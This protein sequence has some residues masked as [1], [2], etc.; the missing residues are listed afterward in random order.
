MA[1]P[2]ICPLCKTSFKRYK[3]FIKH[4]NRYSEEDRKKIFFLDNK[5]YVQGKLYRFIDDEDI[6]D[7]E[8]EEDQE[9]EELEK[10]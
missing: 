3:W 6:N 1:P 9:V 2:Y 8:E 4:I 7:D 10:E 5:I